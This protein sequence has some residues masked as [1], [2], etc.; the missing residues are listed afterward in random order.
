MPA[1]FICSHVDKHL[2]AVLVVEL[3]PCSKCASVSVNL[4][5]TSNPRVRLTHGAHRKRKQPPLLIK[6]EPGR[7]N[8]EG[9][10]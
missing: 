6:P 9:E 2:A 10:K 5:D 7:Q 1:G 3:S 4:S 8:N